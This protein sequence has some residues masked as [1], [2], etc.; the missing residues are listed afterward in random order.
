MPLRAKTKHLAH[1]FVRLHAYFRRE[2][3][4]L[5]DFARRIK[6]LETQSPAEIYNT[7]IH[8]SG[9]AVLQLALGLDLVA[10]TIIPDPHEKAA[11]YALC[12]KPVATDDLQMVG[13]QALVLRQAMVYYAG[14]EAVRQLI[15]TD[16]NPDARAAIDNRRASELIIHEIGGNAEYVVFLFSLARR[17]C[18]LLVA[19]HQ[20][21]IRALAAA[22]QEKL[23]LSGKVAR[24]V[25]LR[26]LARR[27]GRPMSFQTD[28]MLR[29][30]VG[31]VSFRAFLRKLNLPGPPDSLSIKGS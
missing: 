1:Q 29:G 3:E 30:L 8:E 24:K 10:V 27:S 2:L 22:L 17:R 20:P 18:A 23:V 21:E 19:H 28:H 9:H 5:R 14:A 31:D 16:P 12:K 4:Q 13:R 7:A 26:S 6:A 25:F 11:G 15:P